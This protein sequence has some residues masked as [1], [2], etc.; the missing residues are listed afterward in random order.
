MIRIPQVFV[1]DEEGNQ[2]GVM[3]TRDAQKLA[4]ERGL[5]LVE[6]APNQRPPVCRI[7]DYGKFKYEA[8]KKAQSSKRKQ[9]QTQIKEV[10]VRPKI[11]QGDLEVKVRRAREFL[12]KGDKVQIT[13]LFRGREMA[14]Q[15]VGLDVMRRFYEMI[16][17]LAKIEREPRQ[18]D[19][20][21]IMVVAR[22]K[23]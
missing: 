23:S 14:H 9:H 5:D 10:R 4:R 12:E 20:R 15:E 7:M 16:E 8:K 21:M 11:A 3:A 22:R 2:L 17:D 19:R 13:C 1:I 18:E 6:V